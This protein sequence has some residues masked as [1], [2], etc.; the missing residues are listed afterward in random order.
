MTKL[1]IVAS[2][3]IQYYAPWFRH[4]A[5]QTGLQIKVFYLWNFGI[6]Q[7][8]DVAFQTTVQWDIPLLQGYDYEFVPN[9]SRRPGTHHFWGLNN[10]GLVD[11]VRTYGPDAVLLMNYNYIS[12][13]QFLW[14]WPRS[15]APLLFR[16][17]SHVLNA[18]R[19]LKGQVKRHWIRQIYRRFDACL[20][21]GQAN[22][23]Y[24]EYHGVP[25]DKL[26]FAPHAI[27][28]ERFIQAIPQAQRDARHW[29]QL[30]GIPENHRVIL[31]AGK[32]IEKKRPLDLLQAFRYASLDQ[33]SLLFVGSGPLE[34][35]L[36][37]AAADLDQVYFAPFQNQSQ[38]P[39][40]YAI[41]TLF[42]LPSY[43]NGETWG[44]A[45]NEALCLGKPVIISDQ[46]GCAAD[47]VQPEENGWIF[48][49]GD[50]VALRDC[51]RQVFCQTE[52]LVNKGLQGQEIIQQY[53]YKQTTQGLCQALTHLL[54][55]RKPTASQTRS[56]IRIPHTN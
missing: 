55:N 48:P 33:V 31:F 40:T 23:G 41:A 20:Y 54:A 36:R 56:K 29:K 5:Q 47:L 16:G 22:R 34:S 43:G 7:Q 2:H 44:L 11:Q 21:V 24:F 53:S 14:H 1:A 12:L 28:N 19:G 8:Q 26:F 46:V 25:A 32:L 51:L 39:R 4:L 52:N 38:M 35:A 45:I 49:A 9:I 15:Q 13:Y 6:T 30:L 37:T 18:P 10:P 3:P 17:D 27:E 50:V 42:V